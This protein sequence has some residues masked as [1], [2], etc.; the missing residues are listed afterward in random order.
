[1][2]HPLIIS[3]GAE[4]QAPGALGVEARPKCH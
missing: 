1:M 4:N 2:A 3:G